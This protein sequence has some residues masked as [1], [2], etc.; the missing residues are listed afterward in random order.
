M[1]FS[2]KA[3]I[4]A[5]CSVLGVAAVATTAVVLV[6]NSS[7]S[8]YTVHFELCTDLDTTSVN[9]REVEA[10]AFLEEP[11]V[12]V[13]GQ[14]EENWG[15][16]GWYRDKDYEAQWDFDFDTVESDLTLYAKWEKNPQCTVNFWTLDSD[17]AIYTAQIRKGL[18]T[19]PCDDKFIGREVLGYYT[20]K[21]MTKEYD[22]AEKVNKNL[23]LW[24]KLSDYI[25]FSPEAMMQMNVCGNQVEVTEYEA[26]RSISP[27]GKILTLGGKNGAYLWIKNLELAMN[28]TSI[29]QIKAREVNGNYNGL[30]TG[31]IMGNYTLNGEIGTA[32]N[33][34]EKYTGSMPFGQSAEPDEDGFYT[35][36]YNLSS[37]APGLVYDKMTG[38]RF[39]IVGTDKYSFEIKEIRTLVDEYAVSGDAFLAKDGINFNALHLNTFTLMGGAQTEMIGKELLSFGGPNG[40]YIYRKQLEISMGE[41]QII[42]VKAKGDL[43]GG[44]LAMFFFGDYTI[45]GKAGSVTDYN[46]EHRVTFTPEGTDAN[47]FTTYVA[48]I[49]S[50]IPGLKYKTIKGI[51]FDLYGDGT[52]TLQLKSVVSEA[53][54]AEEKQIAADFNA[55]GIN[56]TGKHLNKF[57]TMGGAEKELLSNGDLKLGGKNGAFIHYKNLNIT[58]GDEQMIRLKAKGDLKGGSIALFF[59]GDYTQ[60]GKKETLDDY[61]A[62]H[63]LTL[64]PEST[65]KD[66]YTTYVADITSISGLKYDVIKG[67]RI[68]LYG[69]GTR[70]VEIASVKSSALSKDDVQINADFN[71]T[72]GIHFKGMHFGKFTVAGDAKTSLLSNGD[73]RVGGPNGAMI[74]YKN[75]N[76]K[77]GD[78]QT[79]EFKAK[80]DLNKGS[81][82]LHVYGDYTLNGVKGSLN[83]FDENGVSHHL[84]PSAQGTDADG[85]TLYAVEIGSI[86]G[87]QYNVIKGLRL[88]LYGD[89]ERTIEIKSMD[90]VAPSQ[91]ELELNKA[92]EATGLNLIGAHFTKF[93]AVNGPITE[94]LPSGD[95]KFEGANGVYIQKTDMAVKLGDDQI[96]EFKA[97]T[98]MEGSARIDLYLYGEKADGTTTQFGEK[99]IFEKYGDVDADG[100]QTYRVDLDAKGIHFNEVN[101]LRIDL[102]GNATTKTLEIKSLKSI[103]PETFTVKYFVDGQEKDSE[104]VRPGKTATGS[105][106]ED[107]GLTGEGVLEYYS[108]PACNTL[109]DLEGTVISADTNVYV[110][111]GAGKYPVH[112]YVNG[113]KVYT[114]NV[115]KGEK[116]ELPTVEQVAPGQLILGWFADPNLDGAFDFDTTIN[117]ETN[118]Y[119]ETTDFLYFSAE[120]LKDFGGTAEKVLSLDR[121]YLTIKGKHGSYIHKKNL[122]YDVPGSQTIVVKAKASTN[123][124]KVVIYLFGEY[125]LG[126]VAQTPGANYGSN[127]GGF[128]AAMTAGTT[129]ADGY[130]TYTLNLTTLA[131][132]ITFQK[133]NGF[134]IDIEGDQT[135]DMTLDVKE[136]RCQLPSLTPDRN[137]LVNG[138]FDLI[139]DWKN[140]DNTDVGEQR[141]EDFMQVTYYANYDFEDGN[142]WGSNTANFTESDGNKCLKLGSGATGVIGDKNLTGLEGGKTYKLKLRIKADEANAGWNLYITNTEENVSGYNR[143]RYYGTAGTEWIVVEGEFTMKSGQTTGSLVFQSTTETQFYADDITVTTENRVLAT[144]DVEIFQNGDFEDGSRW[145]SNTE[146]VTE[147][148]GNKCLKLGSGATGVIGDKTLT[149]LEGGKTYKLKFEIKA[150]VADAGWNLYITNTEENVSG[151]NRF[152]YYGTAQTGWTVVEGEFTMKAGQTSGALVFQSTTETQFYADDIS[153][154]YE[155]IATELAT[156]LPTGAYDFEDGNR[157]GSNTENIA[158]PDGNKCLKLGSGATGVI[159]DKTLTGLEGGKTY[160]LRLRIK[161]DVADAGWNLYITNTEENVSGYNRYRYYGT[162]GTDWT[163]VE[164]EFT[165]KAGQTSG[166]LVFQSTTETLFYIDDV[167]VMAE[168]QAYK[169][170]YTDGI[171][172]ANGSE[173]NNVLAMVNAEEVKQPVTLTAGVTYEYSV[174]VKAVN[175]ASS[176]V[177]GVKY[178]TEQQ[179]KTVTDGWTTV[180]GTITAGSGPIDFG[181]YRSGAGTV[182]IDDVT[183]KVK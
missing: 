79:I 101:G 26:T 164:G 131:D 121:S 104:K 132:G 6:N 10:G 22:F 140:K 35:Y 16:G 107:L 123:V 139:S 155:T 76:I 137:Y 124:Q 86:K 49:T 166:A 17:K 149:G 65:D 75:L 115:V 36:T 156:A 33:F 28:G 91:E 39:G 88:N 159:G 5:L 161:A 31:F 23:D 87:L 125:S 85:Y 62:K 102:I 106:K 53:P 29:I 18:T 11:E 66:G 89:G 40:A 177:F 175:A 128:H 116:A 21:E 154:T 110:K 42:R 170:T 55:K 25:Y 52:R 7:K 130:T 63:R 150:D 34:G 183:L 152:R 1:K 58:M 133:I 64:V 81:V 160:T 56:F 113:A 120:D 14:N 147:I 15:I 146:N 158:E 2:P 172:T 105:T 27:D 126:G 141:L 108:D 127:D 68:D 168:Q 80:G 122:S 70:T 171:G 78:E 51:R 112:F 95:F 38:F 134:R 100:Y 162:V 50:A 4:I 93:R 173:D 163:I 24:V 59:F 9:D 176:L 136:V 71:A 72:D 98:E 44:A 92:F 67:F 20:D 12:Y 145:G 90:S 84:R 77:M 118:V 83:N 94:L 174:R 157:W 109:F 151:Y 99:W 117:A 13:T 54:N 60:N 144:E 103:V 19:S 165:M 37:L 41:E 61:N 135:N 45:N 114:Q 181:F 43:K 8:G 153:V 182:L 142:R 148:D 73:F 48:D 32:G 180:T 57:L 74:Y 119:V 129:D 97:K 30:L 179:A 82:T 169:K 69:E 178:G 46:G 167:D 138:G 143:F 111:L 47:G 3:L 96:I